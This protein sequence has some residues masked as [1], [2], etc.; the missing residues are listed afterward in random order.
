MSRKPP[1]AP[2]IMFQNMAL[3]LCGVDSHAHLDSSQFD[4]DREDVLARAKEC[5]VAHIG[6]IFL[7]PHEFEARA[8]YFAQHPEV[9]FA[10]GIHPCD[11]QDCDDE[12][13]DVMRAHFAKEPRLKAVGEIGL[14]FYWDACPKDVQLHAFVLQ[15]QMAR[16]LNLPVIIHSR[17]A[18]EASIALLEKEDFKD[19]PLLWHCFGGNAAE[20]KRIVHNGWHVSIPG[21]VTYPKNADLREAVA[22]IPLDRLMLETDCPYLSP[23][24][25]RGKRNEPAYTV[26]TVETVAKVL[27]MPAAKLWE[28]CGENARKFF[29]L[30][31]F[32]NL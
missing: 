7:K 13:M 20:A 23:Q 10:L 9:F 31:E 22:H 8:A 29:K 15:L 12:A 11:A 30:G 28:I 14:D 1:L 3:P 16:E 25:W 19:Y 5:G 18:T 6:N 2:Q 26:C 21:P 27:E 4:R 17:D 24:E 32:E